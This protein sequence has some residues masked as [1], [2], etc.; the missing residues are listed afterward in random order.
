VFTP[1]CRRCEKCGHDE[2]GCF[3]IIGYPAS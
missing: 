2:A 1:T 3:E